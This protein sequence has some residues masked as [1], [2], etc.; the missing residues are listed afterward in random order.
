MKLNKTMPKK[1]APPPAMHDLSNPLSLIRKAF[2][3]LRPPVAPFTPDAGWS[4][5][6]HDISSHN[7]NALQ[8]QLTLQ[9][10]PHGKLRIESFRNGPQG[11]RYYT[12]AELQCRNDALRTPVAWQ[13]ESKVATTA[14][15]PDYLKSG[16]TKQ[17]V[18]KDGLLTL[19]E[20]HKR[21]TLKLPGAY[22]CK[23]CLLD[24]VG[25]LATAGIE[26]VEF[27]LIDEYDARCPRQT[28]CFRGNE[29]V[30]TQSGPIE[31]SCYQHTGTA[32]MPGVFYVDARGRTLFY[33]AGM[34]LLALASVDGN[35][36]GYLK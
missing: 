19:Q 36:T 34:E 33:L 28:L 9:H 17:A 27:T 11:Y 31:V 26:K 23:W 32:T 10:Q 7:L 8:G 21:H 5:L 16:L 24:A 3:R 18:V 22:T 14:D 6:Y 4:H 25:A 1:N 2:M 30:A 13:V 12:I 20:G 35:S 15:G 29:M